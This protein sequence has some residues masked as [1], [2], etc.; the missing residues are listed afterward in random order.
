M[1]LCSKEIKIQNKK[2]FN[3]FWRIITKGPS[4]KFVL[5]VR[6]KYLNAVITATL[7]GFV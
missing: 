2:V 3:P 6:I 7:V 5:S 1:Y 4:K